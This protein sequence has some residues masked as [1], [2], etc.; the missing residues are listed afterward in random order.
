MWKFIGG[1]LVLAAVA[2][3]VFAIS[4]VRWLDAPA[5]GSGVVII[6]RGASLPSIADRL[7][8]AAVL[9][10]PSWFRWYARL[11]GVS[12]KIHSGEYRFTA[13]HTP[14]MLLDDLVTGNVVEHSFAIIE[15]WTL[16]QAL[17]AMRAIDILVD[18]LGDV[19]TP[20]ADVVEQ[21]GSAEGWLFPDTYRFRRG[22]RASSLVAAAHS[23]MR[24]VLGM[25]WDSRAD[26][27]PYENEY[28]ALTMASIIE[29]E[30][31]FDADRASIAQVFV[32]RLQRG[33]RL[34]SD[35]TVIYGIGDSFDGNLTRQHLRTETP[36]NSY[37]RAGLPPTPISLPGLAS[38]DAA[39]HPADSEFLYFV[40][41]GDGRSEFS[42]TLEAHQDAVRRYQLKQE[43]TSP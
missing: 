41:R 35:P 37:R 19:P 20:L 39:L 24:A 2:T 29:K 27:L 12:Q 26:G 28:E 33:M 21:Y 30:T 23:R 17:N 9:R 25:A 16:G 11:S 43:S 31:G 32:T 13:A 10:N 5:G 34:Q 15:G 8:A 36:Y 22:D 40:A 38:I 7:E 42:V 4:V 6:E 18:D 1:I 3:A 14:R